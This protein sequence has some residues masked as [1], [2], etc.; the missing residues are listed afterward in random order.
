MYTHTITTFYYKGALAAIEQ[1]F[2]TNVEHIALSFIDLFRKGT[3]PAAL[4]QVFVKASD[5]LHSADWSFG[6]QLI[7]AM[8]G[9]RDAM[10]FNQWRKEGF[11]VKKGEKSFYILAPMQ[12]GYDRQKTDGTFERAKYTFGFK[13]MPV[14]GNTQVADEDGNL[15]T[16]SCDKFLETSPL[17]DVANS[18][19]L[20]VTTYDGHSG[21]AAGY[22]SPTSS[23]IA[24]GVKN[25]STFAH[26]LVHA[27]DDKNGEL[28]LMKYGTNKKERAN[29]EIVAELGGAV[30]LS[31]MGLESE[32]DLGGC[33]EYVQAYAKGSNQDLA[34]VCLQLVNR[35]G[36][37]VKLIL[38]TKNNVQGL[39]QEGSKIAAA[40]V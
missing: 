24:L 4:G 14:F 9:Y 27:A 12:K 2:A 26:E 36:R 33:W 3:L 38:E 40:C 8:A 19:G 16:Y 28:D 39:S 18:W 25:L 15:P 5:E 7:V 34:N 21:G 1:M 31:A 23:T 6:N 11:G 17:I 22:Y 10:T 35:I 37:A 30:L 20:S 29:A 32:A 13:G